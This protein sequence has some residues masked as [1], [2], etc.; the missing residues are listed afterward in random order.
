M[1][2][3]QLHSSNI[4]GI[5]YDEKQK[6]L[7][8]IFKNGASYTYQNVPKEVAEAYAKAPS[9]RKFQDAYIHGKYNVAAKSGPPPKKIHPPRH[10]SKRVVK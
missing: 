10:N 9:P 8:V 7:T 3:I 1:S 2:F 5:D 4:Q 6:N